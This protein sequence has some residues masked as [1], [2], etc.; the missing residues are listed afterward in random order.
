MHCQMQELCSFLWAMA[1]MDC[2]IDLA[3]VQISADRLHGVGL[4]KTN[5]LNAQDVANITWALGKLFGHMLG[6][7]G[8]RLLDMLQQSVADFAADLTSSGISAALVGLAKMNAKPNAAMLDAL[9]P[10][11][12]SAQPQPQEVRAT[13]PQ[14]V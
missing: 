11:L 12:A 5:R 8:P 10:S 3:F 6:E 4:L 7:N 14:T 1:S 9:A 13:Q 2:N